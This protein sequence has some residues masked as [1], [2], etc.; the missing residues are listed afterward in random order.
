[1]DKSIQFICAGIKSLKEKHELDLNE[2]VLAIDKQAPAATIQALEEIRNETM[3]QL[4]SWRV[5]LESKNKD[6]KPTKEQDK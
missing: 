1:M 5:V 6:K 4:I 3:F 2:L